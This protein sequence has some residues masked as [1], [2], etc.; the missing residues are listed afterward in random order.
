MTASQSMIGL[1]ITFRMADVATPSALTYIA[2]IGDMNLPQDDTDMVEATHAASPGRDREFVFGLNDIGELSFDMNLAPGSMSDVMLKAAKG[3][4][5]WCEV[6]FPNGVQILFV[7]LRQSYEKS[8]PVDDKLGAS[9]N[10]KVSGGATMTLPVAPFNIVAPTISGSGQVEQPLV[11]NVGVWGGAMAYSY[12]WLA[13]GVA[14]SGAT[15]ISYVPDADQDGA[16]ITCRVT[17]SNDGYSTIF[18][19]EGITLNAGGGVPLASL[20]YARAAMANRGSAPFDIMVFGDSV[21]DGYGTT[22][23]ANRFWNLL[24]QRLRT[25]F[26]VSGGGAGFISSRLK[27]NS[28]GDQP[29]NVL[30]FSGG[31]VAGNPAF[32]LDHQARVIGAGN[33]MAISFTGTGIDIDYTKYSGGGTFSWSVDGGAVTNIATSNATLATGNTTQIRGLS[34]T[35]H[36]IVITGVSGTSY[37]NGA[38]A[39]R[40]DENSGIRTSVLSLAGWGTKNFWPTNTAQRYFVASTDLRSPDLVVIDVLY[41]DFGSIT[42]QTTPADYKANIQAMIA[43]IKAELGYSPSFLLLKKWDITAAGSTLAPL[44]DY[45]VKLYEIAAEDPANVT[46]YA[47][48]STAS[49]ITKPDGTHPNDAGNVVV[50]NDLDAWLGVQLAAG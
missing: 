30:S 45:W 43:A 41:N 16:E 29:D 8:A 20:S 12:Q 17:A 37:I 39:Y 18:T 3:S 28:G 2:E 50:A 4:K 5:R 9:V 10:F 14:I 21:D 36:T 7:G 38:F 11:L 31:S 35:S 26:N 22:A 25:R 46:V 33:T 15:G 48:L 44:S 40:G 24:T 47:G 19:T 13:D 42:A 27:V 34:D 1:G 49:G 6:T 32:G 23:I